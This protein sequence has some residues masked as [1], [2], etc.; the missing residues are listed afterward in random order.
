M[1]RPGRQRSY[2]AWTC[3]D[4]AKN[5]E[6]PRNDPDIIEIWGYT[7]SFSYIAGDEV[8]LHIHTTADRFDLAVYRDG[9][10]RIVVH[11]EEQIT[12]VRQNT[13]TNAHAVGCGWTEV[14]SFVV[15]KDWRS[16]TYI[17]IFR[18][19][20]EFGDVLERETFFVVRPVPDGQPINSIVFV[21]PTSTY[22]AYNDWG[23]ANA[24]RSFDFESGTMTDEIAPR[25]SLN[26][27][28]GRGFA[29]LPVGAPRYADF[30]AQEPFGVP[31]YPW[32]EFAFT[33]QYSRHYADAGWALFDRPFAHWL[34]SQDYEVDYLTLHDLHAN[35]SL[36]D[37]YSVMVI[38]GHD[39]YWSAAMRDTVDAF[40]ESGG[41]LARFGG[42][43]MWQVRMEDDNNT[44]VCYKIARNDPLHETENRHLTTTYWEA[45]SVARPGA[46]T[47]GVCGM[48]GTYTRMPGA[49]PRST[50]AMTVYE[51]KHWV[52]Q[53]TDLFFA[54]SFGGAPAYIASFE[55]DGVNIQIVDGKP[56]PTGRDGVSMDFEI[57]AMAQSA[58]NYEETHTEFPIVG[59]RTQSDAVLCIDITEQERRDVGNVVMG[60]V[61]KG[62]G[63][64]FV[65][66]CTEWVAGLNHHDVMVEQITH[67]V[68]ERFR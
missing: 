44:Q 32:L 19:I 14:C 3:L 43:F 2:K 34:E 24:Y 46:E 40:V 39:E 1:T 28:W 38:T 11:T 59:P 22:V 62:S 55:V 13:P 29:R 31:R 16:G 63:Q 8:R 20:D 4:W 25:L 49:A 12:G 10:E 41:N 68:L 56:Q 65:V 47:V 21:L 6:F 36:L 50:G 66:G 9:V 18:T 33:Y 35:S 67:N 54:D 51:P 61:T 7:D 42:N 48:S 17:A 58:G 30:V 52:F 5:L 27:P 15:G 37:G 23:G 60:V 26:R 57:L 45:E 53:S 64:I